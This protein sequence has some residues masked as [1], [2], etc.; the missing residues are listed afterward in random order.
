MFANLPNQFRRCP[1]IILHLKRPSHIYLLRLE[2]M[3]QELASGEFLQDTVKELCE[4]I[5][6][7]QFGPQSEFLLPSFSIELWF[8]HQEIFCSLL[9]MPQAWKQ[10]PTKEAWNVSPL[11]LWDPEIDIKPRHRIHVTDLATKDLQLD[12]LLLAPHSLMIVKGWTRMLAL[13]TVLA[14]L[15]EKAEFME[16]CRGG[17]ESWGLS[18][19]TQVFHRNHEVWML[20]A[21]V[22]ELGLKPSLGK[23]IGLK[24][25]FL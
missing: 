23:S 4:I 22:Q 11:P 21:R 5:V 20:G 9:M 7:G 2:S 19:V 16:A 6:S 18:L 3:W 24:D 1:K 14:A 10:I 8:G 15:Y 13:Y 17:A 12:P 25:T